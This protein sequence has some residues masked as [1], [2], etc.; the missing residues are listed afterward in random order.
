MEVTN[1]KVKI[2]SLLNIILLFIKATLSPPVVSEKTKKIGA[3]I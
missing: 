2:T 3:R 1:Y